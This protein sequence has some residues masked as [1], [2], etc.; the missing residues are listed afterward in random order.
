MHDLRRVS[1]RV[2][3]ELAEQARARLLEL[4]PE[5]FEELEVDGVVELAAYLGAAGERQLR[6]AFGPDLHTASVEP[7]WEHR[8][9][10][11]HRPVVAGGIWIGPPWD[12]PPTGLPSVVIDPGLAF[13]TGG[14]PT[15]RLC[16][17]L[18]ATVERGSLLDIGCG[19]GIL[20]IAGRRLGFHPV[21][22]VDVDPVAVEV[23]AAN[24]SANGVD[25]DVRL[26]DAS[27]DALPSTDVVVANI[28]LAAVEDVLDRVEPALAVTSGYLVGEG[29]EARGWTPRARRGLDGWAADLLERG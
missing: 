3:P 10:S 9:R 15:T 14:H 26:A 25:V 13:G 4:V 2:P 11:F 17:E 16:V 7:G 29:P 27:A 8:W 24:A 5:G 21:A 12:P 28:T 23:T 6:E 19:S 20:A 22:A 18:L 1:L